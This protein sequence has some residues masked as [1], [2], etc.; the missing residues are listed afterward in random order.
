MS[1]LTMIAHCFLLQDFSSAAVGG[2]GEGIQAWQKDS[3]N[4]LYNDYNLRLP[5]AFLY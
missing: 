5:E 3:S 4:L 1:P 2:L